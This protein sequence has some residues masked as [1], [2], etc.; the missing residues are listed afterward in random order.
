MYDD[1]FITDAEYD[2]CEKLAQHIKYGGHRKEYDHC[3]FVNKN[4]F[5]TMTFDKHDG[6][7][8]CTIS[9]HGHVKNIEIGDIEKYFYIADFDVVISIQDLLK[10]VGEDPYRYNF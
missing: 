10:M 3:E 5:A 2:F 8:T 7:F 6:A 9:I 1:G 4:K